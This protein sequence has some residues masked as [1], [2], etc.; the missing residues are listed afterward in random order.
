MKPFTFI[1]PLGLFFASIATADVQLELV[2][3][4]WL[5]GRPS[6]TETFDLAYSNSS[7]LPKDQPC[8]QLPY[9]TREVTLLTDGLPGPTTCWLYSQYCHESIDRVTSAN[10]SK[11]MTNAAVFAARCYLNE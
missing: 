8:T 6:R 3:V 1:L 4:R 2:E 9:L 5:D 7:L 10:P 11:N